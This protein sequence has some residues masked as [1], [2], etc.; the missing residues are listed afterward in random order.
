[1]IKQ[2]GKLQGKYAEYYTKVAKK[3]Q[4]NQGYVEKE[5]TRLTNLISKGSLAP[6]KLDDLTSR[7]NILSVFAG[8]V[9]GAADSVKEAAESVKAE[10]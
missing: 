8:K 4:D 9:A 3:A 1:M 10:L 6:E 7:K 5:L 2:A